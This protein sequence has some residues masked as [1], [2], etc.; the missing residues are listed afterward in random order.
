LEKRGY[1]GKR[2][3][4]MDATWQVVVEVRRVGRRPTPGQSPQLRA[5]RPLHHTLS[6][7]QTQVD[8]LSNT[9]NK[10][11]RRRSTTTARVHVGCRTQH[12]H[13]HTRKHS[14]TGHLPS[15]LE[16]CLGARGGAWVRAHAH[17]FSPEETPHVKSSLSLKSPS[18]APYL[19][20]STNHHHPLAGEERAAASHLSS[21][22]H[23]RSRQ[24]QAREAFPP[25]LGAC[26]LLPGPREGP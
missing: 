22:R 1:R 2:W 26:L 5:D 12:T 16:L 11:Y 23:S 13:T 8:T 19:V 18:S 3:P 14:C 10:H 7:S 21:P 15:L 24:L 9:K 20:C 17:I 4:L 25:P 6:H